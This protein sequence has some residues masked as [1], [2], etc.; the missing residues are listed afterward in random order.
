MKEKLKNKFLGINELSENKEKSLILLLI[1]IVFIGGVV[2]YIKSYKDQEQ[3]T[4]NV[5]VFNNLE[6]IFNE[7]KDYKYDISIKDVEGNTSLF[8]GSIKDGVDTGTKT[9]G[10]EIVN[11]K[12][13]NNIITNTDTNQIIDN[14]YDGYLSYFFKADNIY[15]YVSFLSGETREDKD[16]KI[17]SYEYVYDDKNISFEITTTVNRISSIVITYDDHIYNIKYNL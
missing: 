3:T 12:N 11:Y 16:I 6:T 9:V 17:Y 15:N 1:W 5:F 14:L 13:D 4:Q 8:A 7:Y 10:E 2:I